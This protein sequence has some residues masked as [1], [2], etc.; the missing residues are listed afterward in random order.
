MS[1]TKKLILPV[2]SQ[3]RELLK[4]FAKN[5]N[6]NQTTRETCI[7]EFDIEECIKNFNCG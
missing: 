3:Q 6:E 4:F 1:N 7:E 5:W 2:V